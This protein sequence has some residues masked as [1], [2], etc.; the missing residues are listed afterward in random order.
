METPPPLLE[1]LPPML[2]HIIEAIRTMQTKPQKNHTLIDT[3]KLTP[4]KKSKIKSEATKP[5]TKG[6]KPRNKKK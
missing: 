2:K 4:A 6:R 3:R 1:P 5:E